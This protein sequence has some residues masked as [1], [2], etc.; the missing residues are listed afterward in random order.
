MNKL[1][2]V[3]VAVYNTDKYLSRCLD[4]IVNQTYNNIEIIVVNDGSL[5]NSL[6]IIKDYKRKDK[7][8]EL[9]DKD[10][11]GLASTRNA[12]IRAA[13]GDFLLFVDSDDFLELNAIEVALNSI[14][15]Y[16]VEMCVFEFSIEGKQ[17]EANIENY[18]ILDNHNLMEYLFKDEKITSHSWRKLYPKKVFNN[19][20]F[21]EEFVVVQ[22]MASDHYFLRNINKAVLISDC[23]Y[24]Y[25]D[26][27]PVNL[28]NSNA[29]KINSSLYR[30][31][32]L[33]DRLIFADKYYKD[34]S[35]LIIPQLALFLLSSYA[36]L[37]KFDKN[38][39]NDLMFIK[40]Y[41]KK[42]E[43]RF[44]NSS[45]LSFVYKIIIKAIVNDNFF[46]TNVA[47]F[48][49]NYFLNK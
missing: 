16:K 13:K 5:D 34:L 26:E 36:K 17:K 31:K 1:V 39:T 37:K 46:I 15:K 14:E 38:N 29:K 22:D 30:A 49:Y 40:N 42:E 10:N 32:A 44:I 2:S 27:N 4:S 20:S 18:E 8:I 45:S 6:E 33:I 12:G 21:N 47:C 24:V 48:Y 9:I 19:S 11:G 43:E 25:N 35:E 23:L 41:L 3:L 7:R 28:S